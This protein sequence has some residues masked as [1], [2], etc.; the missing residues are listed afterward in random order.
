MK[1]SKLEFDLAMVTRKFYCHKCGDRLLRNARTRTIKRGDP[2][3]R[4]YSRMGLGTYLIGDIEL[5]EYDFKCWTCDRII[6]ADE[7]YVFEKMQKMLG[8]HILTDEEVAEN[9]EKAKAA[10]A[11][12]RKITEIVVKAV[13][14]TLM[15]LVLFYLI[16]TKDEIDFRFYF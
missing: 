6:S 14:I 5:T 10:V 11:K 1:N 8:K 15:L 9:E 2:D 16:I 7:Q 3:Y 4:K 12:K 13:S